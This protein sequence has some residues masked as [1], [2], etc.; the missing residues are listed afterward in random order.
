MIERPQQ[1]RINAWTGD[2]GL[3]GRTPEGDAWEMPSQAAIGDG[4]GAEEL[5]APKPLEDLR[6]WEDPNVGWGLLLPENDALDVKAKAAAEDAPE[7]LRRL[8]AARGGA[9]VLRWGPRVRAGHL[10]RYYADG[11]G[12][13]RPITRSEFGVAPGRIPRYLL[14]YAT[15]TE[16]PWSVQYQLNLTNFVGRLTLTGEALENY[17]GALLTDWAGMAHQRAKPVIWS[18]DKGLPDITW[19]MA[20]ALG[21]ELAKAFA[22]D[23]DYQARCWITG[24][25]ATRTGLAD[26]LS[27]NKPGLICTTSHGMTAPLNDPARLQ[28]Q[29][30]AP[31][32]A[33]NAVVGLDDL[34]DWSPNGAIWYSHACCSAGS[35]AET[36]YADLFSPVD[37][38]GV[39]LRGVAAGAGARAS[40][41]AEALLGHSKPLRAFVGHV[42][43]T[44]DW[45]LKD[46]ISKDVDPP[47]LVTCLYQRLHQADRRCP[48][49]W[50]LEDNFLDSAKQFGVYLTTRVPGAPKPADIDPLYQQLVARDRQTLV[51]LGDP[52]VSLPL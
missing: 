27:A 38:L 14:I 47:K 23:E 52:T 46:P 34:S 25:R 4:R 50:A 19:L 22:E 43:P 1:L 36:R 49:G 15:P 7:P 48:I 13:P 51:V 41:L 29:L 33:R 17:V 31:V 26:A 45:T 39:T 18:T 21:A 37:R 40:P 9:P 16:I 42:E 35:D 32:D 20:R 8:L 11:G 44:F 24:P 12:H 10:M 3:A 6:C 28:A 5:Y 2:D 30:G